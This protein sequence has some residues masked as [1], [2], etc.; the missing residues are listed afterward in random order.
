MDSTTLPNFAI[1][2]VDFEHR[3]QFKLAYGEEAT[4]ETDPVAMAYKVGAIGHMQTLLH[5]VLATVSPGERV[6]D[7]GSHLGGF[8]LSAAALGLE[9][10]A[11]EGSPRNAGL[12]KKSISL[13]GFERADVV[14][15][16]IS[17]KPGVVKFSA[18]G[19]YG[20]LA[21]EATNLPS[22]SVPAITIDQLARERGWN[23]V[24]FI[25]LDI[26]GSE[27]RAIRGM[28]HLLRTQSPLVFFESNKHALGFYKFTPEV[29]KNEL[30]KRGY[31][32]YAVE[33]ELDKTDATPPAIVLRRV[34]RTDVQT[35]I[36]TDYL[37]AKTLPPQLQA[38]EEKSP[39]TFMEYVGQC[40]GRAA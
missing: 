26:E 27:V 30:R 6:L 16:C 39:L 38:K 23:N 15:A 33:E 14:H 8:T 28:N 36:N 18:H 25:K 22:I 35:E 19:P 24:R 5:L 7:L 3:F 34:R 37:A 1:A 31:S 29:L 9:V 2:T 12:V 21:C 4:P 13:N 10:L 20:H 17:D 32:V 40:F 11:V